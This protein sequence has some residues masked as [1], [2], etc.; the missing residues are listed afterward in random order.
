MS[1]EVNF[2]VKSQIAMELLFMIEQLELMMANWH[3]NRQMR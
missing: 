1:K 2:L 3:F